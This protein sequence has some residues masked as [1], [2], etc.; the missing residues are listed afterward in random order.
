MLLGLKVH[1]SCVANLGISSF[2]YNLA[3]FESSINNVVDENGL[4]KKYHM[5][6]IPDL[7]FDA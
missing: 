1:D 3:S 7:S 2:R 6:K 5:D 4:K